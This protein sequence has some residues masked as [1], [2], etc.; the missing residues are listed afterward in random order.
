MEQEESKKP[1]STLEISP[2]GDGDNP[3]SAASPIAGSSFGQ[4]L[5]AERVRQAV[6]NTILESPLSS[7]DFVKDDP[8]A[9]ETLEVSED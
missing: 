8:F 5:N 7:D 6:S 2:S 4:P 3:M 1:P 9:I